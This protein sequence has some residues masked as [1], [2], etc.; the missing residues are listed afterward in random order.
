[1]IWTPARTC[2]DSTTLKVKVKVRTVESSA[3]SSTVGPGH[4]RV[5]ERADEP[6]AGL[7]V[8]VAEAVE[9]TSRRGRGW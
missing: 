7:A 5:P 3:S 4:P 6:A 2:I 8:A 1:M 9:A